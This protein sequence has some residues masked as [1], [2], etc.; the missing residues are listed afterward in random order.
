MTL[1][2]LVKDGILDVKRNYGMPEEQATAKYQEIN[3]HLRSVQPDRSDSFYTLASLARL[4]N[5]ARAWQTN[6]GWE[7]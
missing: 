4:H 6:G 2:D 5:Y 7:G 1:D 3:A